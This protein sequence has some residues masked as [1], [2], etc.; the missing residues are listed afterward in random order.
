MLFLMMGKGEGDTGVDVYRFLFHDVLQNH[1]S[2]PV[3]SA[4]C[5][6]NFVSF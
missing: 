2:K 4:Y 3:T 5:A 1:Y 6:D